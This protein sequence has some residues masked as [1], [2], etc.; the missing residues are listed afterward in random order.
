MALKK[1]KLP[2][3]PSAIIRTALA[4]LAAVEKDKKYKINMST[5]HSPIDYIYNEKSKNDPSCEVCMAGAVIANAGNDVNKLIHPDMFDAAT[6]NKLSAIDCFREGE[7]ARGLDYMGI[8]KPRFMT[9]Y[10]EMVD[11]DRNKAKF[12]KQMN[13][14][15]DVFEEYGL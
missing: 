5:W 6:E 10:I 9:G 4:D 7:I 14:L 12:K 15:A 1:L 2:N 13:E 8:E 11:Y 3:K